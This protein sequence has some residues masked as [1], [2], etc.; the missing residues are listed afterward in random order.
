M[1]RGHF[2][3][4]AELPPFISAMLFSVHDDYYNQIG[5]FECA[6]GLQGLVS[7]ATS[8]TLAKDMR[9]APHM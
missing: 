2:L 8:A 6:L 3:S 5:Q 7:V 4:Y 9:H 1:P